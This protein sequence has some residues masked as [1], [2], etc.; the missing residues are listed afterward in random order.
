MFVGLCLDG[1]YVVVE[2]D[3]FA[4]LRFEIVTD[5]EDD[6]LDVNYGDTPEQHSDKEQ[7]STTYKIT[8]VS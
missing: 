5:S 2:Q 1:E 4:C 6:F 7:A 3:K 8:L